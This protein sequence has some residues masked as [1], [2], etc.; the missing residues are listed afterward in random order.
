MELTPGQLA[1]RAYLQSDHWRKLREEKRGTGPRPRCAICASKRRIQLH[2]L[3]YRLR[4]EDTQATDL[5]WLC[6]VCHETTHLLIKGGLTFPEPPNHHS[7]FEITRK[8]VMERRGVNQPKKKPKKKKQKPS[9]SRKVWPK[10]NSKV[11]RGRVSTGSL[12]LDRAI[13]KSDWK[14]VRE[15]EEKMRWAELAHALR[16]PKAT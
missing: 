5:R 14:R 7:V 4:W 12:E 3:F 6:E 8:A 1:Y 11:Q 10:R 9:P 15:I 13:Q 16:W 2:H